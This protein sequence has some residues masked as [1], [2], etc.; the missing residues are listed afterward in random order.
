MQARCTFWMW[1]SD[2]PDRP[3]MQCGKAPVLMSG[4]TIGFCE[5]H[6]DRIVA[7]LTQAV[8]QSSCAPS[9]ADLV[10]RL[11]LTSPNLT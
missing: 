3:G 5:D 8:A 1:A 4:S 9:V 6:S 2:L 10:K 11:G 7:G